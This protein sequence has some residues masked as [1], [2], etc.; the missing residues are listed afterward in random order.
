MKIKWFDHEKKRKRRR[1]NNHI[2]THIP[3]SKSTAENLLDQKVP[4]IDKLKMKKRKNF[5][6]KEKIN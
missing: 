4:F 2:H 1:I 6:Q 3:K 5:K